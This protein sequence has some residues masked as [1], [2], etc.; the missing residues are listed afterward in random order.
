MQFILQFFG[1]ALML[2]DILLEGMANKI[3]AI[4]SVADI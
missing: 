3:K 2:L 1:A 4:S